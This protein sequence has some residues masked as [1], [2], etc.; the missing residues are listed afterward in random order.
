MNM[1]RSAAHYGHAG[2]HY[3][4]LDISARVEAASPHELV[5]ILYEELVGALTLLAGA[6][7]QKDLAR[8]SRA[9][10][11]AIA[12]LAQLESSLD[13][14]KGGQIAPALA[15]ALASIYKETARLVQLAVRD[16]DAAAATKAKG[17]IAEI[18]TAWDAIR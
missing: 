13:F 15:P 8:R 5:S 14:D 9:H 6:V 3:R 10:S 17:L 12:I 1:F 16:D 4:N 2:S 18:W 11:R 7:R